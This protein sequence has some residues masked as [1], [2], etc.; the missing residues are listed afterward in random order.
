[1]IVV[2]TIS[3][4]SAETAIDTLRAFS[5]RSQIKSFLGTYKIQ[6]E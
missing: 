6:T 4:N 3:G 5:G 2:F 1:M